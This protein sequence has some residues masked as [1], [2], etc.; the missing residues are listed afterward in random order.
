MNAP[1]LGLSQRLPPTN[2]AAEQGLLGALMI[3]NG[4]HARLGALKAEHFADLAHARIFRVA[5]DV[6]E[7]GG[8][9]DPVTLRN[10]LLNDPVIE[11]AGGVAYLAQLVTA[12]VS[13]LLAGEYAAQIVDAWVRRQGIDLGAEAVEAWFGAGTEALA[14]LRSLQDRLFRIED[15]VR[16]GVSAEPRDMADVTA[17]VLREHEEAVARGG[18][19]AGISWGYDSLDHRTGGMRPGDLLILAGRPGMGKTA[20]G[21][22][23]AARSAH[24]GSKVLFVS[25]EMRPEG[26]AAR[27]IA[28]LAGLPLGAV[29]RGVVLDPG[30]NAFRPLDAAENGRLIEARRAAAA[31]PI[32]MLRAGGPTIGTIRAAASRQASRGGLD[33]VVIDYLGLLRPP[34]GM[35]PNTPKAV[36]LGEISRA[37][38]LMAMDLGVPVLMLAQINREA[39]KRD[40]KIPVLT[41]LRDSGAIEQD[42]DLVA[43]IHRAEYY[44]AKPIERAPGE[45][46][47][48]FQLREAQRLEQLRAATGRALVVLAK[49]RQGAGG[50]VD[51]R[52][53]ARTTW[54]HEEHEEAALPPV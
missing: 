41:D 24:R 46:E 23:I 33:L 16:T 5:C 42:A 12:C 17:A 54:F 10:R 7:Q 20:L 1:L 36:E 38:K 48:R 30:S 15:S 13:P 11:E 19:L 31:L 22:G 29:L 40:D 50:S 51:L 37:A 53:A 8:V 34:E 21:A 14:V 6:I 32:S 18:G 25:C 4:V 45:A 49:H 28:A 39:A 26:V 27:I 3:H 35:S 2:L 52:F 9:A 44:L 43:F 47:D